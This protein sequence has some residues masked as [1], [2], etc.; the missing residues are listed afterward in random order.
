[1]DVVYLYGVRMWYNAMQAYWTQTN[2]GD[3]ARLGSELQEV[4]RDVKTN[5]MVASGRATKLVLLE[6]QFSWI[7]RL[8]EWLQIAGQRLQLRRVHS[9]GVN[10]RVTII[11]KYR[12]LTGDISGKAT[13]PANMTSQQP[14]IVV[15]SGGTATNELV[16]LFK[17]V[18]TNISY[19]LPILDNGGSTSE[20]IRVTG[21]PAI[22]DIRSRLT[23]LIPPEQEALKKLLSYRLSSDPREAKSQWNHIVDGTHLVW[24]AIDPATREIFRAFLL[25]VHVELLKRSKNLFSLHANKRQFRYELA[26]VGNL[27]LTGGRLF[28]GS[29]DAAIELFA[30]LTGIDRETEVLPCINTN[31]TYHITAL[32]ENGL[33]ITGQSQISHPSESDPK[34]DIHPPPICASPSSTPSELTLK[35]N[36]L[37]TPSAF[38]LGVGEDPNHDR[39]S[40]GSALSEDSSDEESGHAPQY[41]HPAL[42]KS[43]LHFNKS[44]HIEP[45]LSPISRIFYIS[46]YGEEICPTPNNR[47]T[48]RIS[49]ADVVVY[50]IGS[51]MTSIVPI[52]ILKGIGRAIAN[53]LAQEKSGKKKKR[54]LLL[55]GSTDRETFGMSALDFVSVI[56][57]LA[58]YSQSENT[59]RSTSNIEE[60]SN[61]I[62]WNKYVTHLFFMKDPTIEVDRKILTAEKKITC[63]EVEREDGHDY[64]DLED[65]E[66]KLRTTVYE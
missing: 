13:D 65:L 44:D 8:T 40:I 18:S 62:E 29:L 23:R 11:N 12:Y 15:L 22:G 35:G 10:V 17:S 36:L 56:V 9:A 28:I 3:V 38:G 41:T 33:L 60:V 34:V 39:H 32:L 27:F 66:R 48:N 63:V 51:L 21:G 1:M 61:Q 47:V 57:K 45:L 53:D 24:A 20:L 7:S 16:S 50:S 37:E 25:H 58:T 6:M 55:N 26:N 43:Q 4:D 2:D 54:I 64:Y 14:T 30:R 49:N 59:I 46:P 42:K 31:F 52:I 19:I 5:G